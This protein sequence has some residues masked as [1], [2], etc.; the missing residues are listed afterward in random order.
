MT[1]SSDRPDNRTSD[2]V[3]KQEIHLAGKD[4]ADTTTWV[5]VKGLVPTPERGVYEIRIRAKAKQEAKAEDNDTGWQSQPELTDDGYRVVAETAAQLLL[6]DMHLIAKL[7]IDWLTVIPFECHSGFPVRMDC[8]TNRNS[9][10]SADASRT[11]F[12]RRSNERHRRRA[13]CPQG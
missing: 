13:P 2:L 8:G 1:E 3:A 5:D 11:I 9:R 10:P 7:S 4:D 6:T 12:V